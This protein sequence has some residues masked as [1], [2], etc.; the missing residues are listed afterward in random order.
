MKSLFKSKIECAA[1]LLWLCIFI[2]SFF[3]FIF[4]YDIMQVASFG[5]VLLSGHFFDAYDEFARLQ[6][7][8]G[9][10]PIV[11]PL[12][13][14]IWNLPIRLITGSVFFLNITAI[15]AWVMYWNKLLAVVFYILMGI[16]IKKIILKIDKDNNKLTLYYYFCC[17]IA[18]FVSC[19]MGIYD[20]VYT[21]VFTLALYFY[22]DDWKKQK[23]SR[24]LFIL[25]S[26]LSICFKTLPLFY[27]IPLILI[28]EKRII[29]LVLD[30]FVFALPYVIFAIPFLHSSAFIHNCLLLSTNASSMLKWAKFGDTNLFIVCMVVL[31]GVCYFKINYNSANKKIIFFVCNIVSCLLFGLNVNHPQW[32]ILSI[33]CIV[34]TLA[35]AEKDEFALV[36]IQFFFS[37]AYLFAQHVIPR[38]LYNAI[39]GHAW[40][41]LLYDNAFF[42]GFHGFTDIPTADSIFLGTLLVFSIFSYKA[43]SVQQES[44]SKK[45]KSGRLK[46]LAFVLFFAFFSLFTFLTFHDAHSESNLTDNLMSYSQKSVGLDAKSKQEISTEFLLKYDAEIEEVSFRAFT[47]NNDYG[48]AKLEICISE[49]E[50]DSGIAYSEKVPLSNVKDNEITVV[51]TNSF[52]LKKGKYKVVFQVDESLSADFALAANPAFGKTVVYGEKA[53]KDYSLCFNIMGKRK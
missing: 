11:Y 26:G 45:D 21:F 20:S 41:N 19:I 39:F 42:D 53:Y 48:D 50:N 10:Y 28:K 24:W 38:L 33:P 31:C 14:A 32:Y 12:L 2:F 36:W 15:P 13:Y 8:I 1:F 43:G 25:L 17:P 7:D 37:I 18:F 46:L 29:R 6:G 34:I 4:L 3:S 23:K 35:L 51:K 52:M 5:N 16:V 40:L 30:L 47:W 22:I 27:F 9:I 49:S 44:D